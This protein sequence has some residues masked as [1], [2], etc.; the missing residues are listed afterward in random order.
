MI[1]R[2]PYCQAPYTIMPEHIGLTSLCQKC[3][4]QF[5]IEEYPPSS[6][7]A[8]V[9]PKGPQ[10]GGQGA[11][12]LRSQ[13]APSQSPQTPHSQYSPG[14]ASSKD[15]YAQPEKKL[16]RSLGKDKA[17]PDKSAELKVKPQ[18]GIPKILQLALA[19][20]LVAIGEYFFV[21]SPLKE[22]ADGQ[23]AQIS[24]LSS[25]NKAL[26]TRIV[27][28]FNELSEELKVIHDRLQEDISKYTQELENF[29]ARTAYYQ[30][31]ST[32]IIESKL[33]DALILERITALETGAKINTVI[34]QTEPNPQL[35]DKLSAAMA[36]VQAEIETLASELE[37][38]DKSM[39]AN[40]LRLTIQTKR[41]ILATLER[42]YLTAKYGLNVPY[43]VD[44][45]PE[46][47]TVN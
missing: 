5:V 42:N 25:Q 11:Q 2:C 35:A 28:Q 38:D 3:Q 29:S 6:K 16:S 43:Q 30:I 4:E 7:G 8:A 23:E 31:L 44:A 40:T 1:S 10:S 12:D 14:A 20:I 41:L 47:E 39:A 13:G 33:L 45:A 26:Q 36:S 9:E 21:V 46:V 27:S 37:D 32:V 24:I 15:D 17:K 34:N 19:V 22:K 18:K